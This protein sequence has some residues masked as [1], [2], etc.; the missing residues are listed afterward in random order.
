MTEVERSTSSPVGPALRWLSFLRVIP[1]IALATLSSCSVLGGDT[2]PPSSSIQPL[3][4]AERILVDV[5]F[6]PGGSDDKGTRVLLIGFPKG[7]PRDQAVEKLTKVLRA[8]GWT[9]ASC[10]PLGDPCAL[11]PFSIADLVRTYGTAHGLES[12]A[13]KLKAS[14]FMVWLGDV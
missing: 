3:P 13:R 11:I 10:S 14:S 12:R 2:Y 4:R 9:S 5:T 6:S 7:E 1:L 8:R